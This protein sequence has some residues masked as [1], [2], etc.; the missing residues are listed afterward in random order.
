MATALIR[1]TTIDNCNTYTTLVESTSDL[2]DDV[3]G[4]AVGDAIRKA[5]KSGC[6]PVKDGLTV[7]IKFS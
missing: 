7:V 1:I 5:W 6:D 2:P 3:M 4:E